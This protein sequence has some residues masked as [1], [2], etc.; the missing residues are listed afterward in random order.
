MDSRNDFD[1]ELERLEQLLRNIQSPNFGQQIQRGVENTAK[2]FSNTVNSFTQQNQQNQQ[3]KQAPRPNYPNQNQ[4]QY[5]N[6]QYG[7]AYSS[8]G[9][10]QNAQYAPPRQGQNTGYN[11]NYA[12]TSTYQNGSASGQNGSYG[13]PM[14]PNPLPKYPYGVKPQQNQQ[15]I[16][17]QTPPQQSVPAK[18]PPTAVVPA[19]KPIPGK[20]ASVLLRTFGMIGLIPT[21]LFY[22]FA[23]PSTMVNSGIQ[24]AA[25]MSAGF[26]PALGV[27]AVM[28]FAG[29]HM[30]SRVKRC[31]K[32]RELFGNSKMISLEQLSHMTGRSKK[33]LIKDLR[34]MVRR[35]MLS[36]VYFDAAQTC[37]ILDDETYHQYQVLENRRKNLESTQSEAT[38]LPLQDT[39]DPNDRLKYIRQIRAANDA[40][41]GKEI[42]EKL[43]R[44][45]SITV[46]IYEH[47]DKHPEKIDQVRKFMDYY[48][49]TTTKLVS[50]YQEFEA[51]P[52]QGENILGAKREIEEMLDTICK[53]F[54]NL[55]DSMFADNAMDISSDISVME[56]MFKQDGLTKDDISASR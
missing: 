44:L 40:L 4:N 29:F 8:G 12:N 6:R 11:T 28:T 55:L 23:L 36:S 27:F 56:T 43:F 14:T 45:E 39:D 15:N 31:K 13:R 41:P 49:P 19:Q 25:S 42:S 35:G 46:K 16:Y 9:A 22:F 5:Q 52:V 54:E 32:Y 10:R 50:A 26:L 30:A 51:Q 33:F 1:K 20:T 34:K 3:P 7:Q 24:A 18:R 38:R 47:I 2:R 17:R 53:A 48:M 37:V 21:G